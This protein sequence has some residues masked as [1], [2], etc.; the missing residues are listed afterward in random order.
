MV[1]RW[2]S[3]IRFSWDRIN[4]I[5]DILNSKRKN[6]QDFYFRFDHHPI[7]NASLHKIRIASWPFLKVIKIEVI[8]QKEFRKNIEIFFH[9]GLRSFGGSDRKNNHKKV[10]G[11]SC[12]I[13]GRS[14]IPEGV[15]NFFNLHIPVDLQLKNIFKLL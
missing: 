4:P 5:R 13:F 11:N 1:K 2:F 9:R 14:L 3:F 10:P 12:Y 7:M 6:N 8:R 15:V